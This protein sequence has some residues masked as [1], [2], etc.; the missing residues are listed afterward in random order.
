MPVMFGV[1]KYSQRFNDLRKQ[2]GVEGFF[3]H[4]L[5][6]T[7]GNTA[8]LAKSD[9]SLVERHFDLLHAVPK[10]KPN[11]FIKASSV[12]NEAGF[13]DVDHA[14][15]QYNIYDNVWS[16]GDAS[17]LPTSKTAAAIT[18]PAPVIVSNTLSSLSKRPLQS[19][20]NGYA[21]CPLLTEYGKVMIAEFKYGVTPYETFS[22]L[23]D[24][25]IPRRASYHL[26][27]D[28]FPW[29]YYKFMVKGT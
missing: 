4:D 11:G 14:T 17:G 26:K 7:D 16:A 1:P 13:V 25:G 10:M 27:K 21:S 2:R 19:T 29:V 6:G 18:A 28:F 8:T 23:V 5:V 12:A 15:L 24:Q 3:Q 9:G 20:Y 22:T